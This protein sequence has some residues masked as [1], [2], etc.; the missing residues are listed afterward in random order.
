MSTFPA[1]SLAPS[2]RAL[3]PELELSCQNRARTQS[4]PSFSLHRFQ[5]LSH[6]LTQMLRFYEV[7]DRLALLLERALVQLFHVIRKQLQHLAHVRHCCGQLTGDEASVEDDAAQSSGALPVSPQLFGLPP[8]RAVG[9]AQ[10]LL[11]LCFLR[12]FAPMPA[13]PALAL[14]SITEDSSVS[15][16]SVYRLC[17]LMPKE[18]PR[19]TK[20]LTLRCA[21]RVGPD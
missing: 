11:A 6:S 2:S 4:L 10:N 12:R 16:F 13:L 21:C 7:S 9:A 20:G 14:A 1:L 15:P 17:F 18:K 3:Q 8:V 5:R 19:L